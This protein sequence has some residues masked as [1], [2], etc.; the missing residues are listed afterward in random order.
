MELEEDGDCKKE[1]WARIQ[2]NTFTRWVNHQLSQVN[3]V[4]HQHRPDEPLVSSLKTDFV[5]GLLLIKLVETLSGRKVSR[6]NKKPT[7]RSQKLE[8]VNIALSFLEADGLTLVNIDST[9]IVDGKLKLILGLVWTLILHY[10][11]GA[12]MRAVKSSEGQES[13]AGETPKQQLLSWI[14]DLLPGVTNLRKGWEDGRQVGALV[15]A[16]A[17]G[18]CPGWK[19]WQTENKVRNATEAM[20]LA[21][22]WLGVAQLLTP[23][24]LVNPN[25]DE[26]SMMTYLAQFR[27]AKAKEGTPIQTE[28]N[29][30]Q[31]IGSGM[32]SF[33]PLLTND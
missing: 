16:T 12:P 1:E 31:L 13:T 10:S 4:I 24:E 26:L 11:I 7:F 20:N 33:E 9:D 2:E 18:L 29:K 30:T 32:E 21:D 8:N 25:V 6:H 27:E 15:D 23:E 14:Q 28:N 17:T 19:E 3:Q 22:L 5:D